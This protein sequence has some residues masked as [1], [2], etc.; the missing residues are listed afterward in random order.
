MSLVFFISGCSNQVSQVPRHEAIIDWIDF[1]VIDGITDQAFHSRLGRELIEDDL[2]DSY[3]IVKFN[4]SQ[5]VFETGYTIKDGD[6]AFLKEGTIIYKVNGYSPKFRLAAK[7]DNEIVLFEVD[8]NPDAKTGTDYLDIGRKVKYIGINS[9]EDGT[10]ELARIQNSSDV[11][12]IVNLLLSSPIKKNDSNKNNGI[13]GTRYF[14][15]FY[16]EDGT[17]TT[18]V[19]WHDDQIFYRDIKVPIEFNEIINKA[20]E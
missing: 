6:A 16:L 15:A 10:T 13:E 7:R 3:S 18:R 19:Y 2:G 1:L 20:F 11:E 8:T 17:V 5:N 9:E 4:V 14:L 12:K